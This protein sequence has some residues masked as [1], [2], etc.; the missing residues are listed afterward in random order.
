LVFYKKMIPKIIYYTWISDK[1]LPQEFQGYIDNWKKIMPDY[2]FEW[3][4]VDNYPKNEWTNKAI[5]IGK[6]VL[7]GHYARCKNIY[8]TGGI[9]LDID[10]EVL[11]PFDFFLNNNFFL[12][13]E[14]DFVINN[15][16]F[17]AV[18]GHPF[19]LDCI[20]Y[21]ENMPLDTP[22]VELE[23]GPRMFTKFMKKRGWE[24]G[25]REGL[26]EDMKLYNKEYFY[27]YNWNEKFTPEC[28][29][30]NTHA[31]HRWAGTWIKK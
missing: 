19:L 12:G 11:K 18:E 31:I 30:P 9:Y 14:D 3:V 13:Q 23:T 17:G 28:I 29:T 20:K 7:A 22:Q 8:E 24:E 5:E 25:K 16:V 15:A 26:F 27:P 10:V 4:N 21:M 6:P 1:P 2:K